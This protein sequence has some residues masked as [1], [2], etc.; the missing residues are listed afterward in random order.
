M[1]TDSHSI[2]PTWR[3]HYSHLFNVHRISDARQTEIQTAEP[4]VPEPSAS[5]A[6]TAIENLKRHKSSGIIKSQQNVLKYGV[7]QF[8]LRTKN[9]LIRLGIRSNCLRSGRS[10]SVYLSIRRVTKEIV[11]I[12]EAH[13]F[14]QLPTKFYPTSCFQG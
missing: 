2:L 3:K 7:E 1:V 11:I 10:R 6:E 5:Q 9:L 8:A 13:N 14:C 4:P 12:I